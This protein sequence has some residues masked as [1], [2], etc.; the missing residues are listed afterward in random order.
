MQHA[1]RYKLA[2]PLVNVTCHMSHTIDSPDSFS[3]PFI[4][5]PRR[6]VALQFNS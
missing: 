3:D 6:I 1:L 2:V 5:L 4:Q